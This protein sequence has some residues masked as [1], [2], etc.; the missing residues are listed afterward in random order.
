[1]DNERTTLTI[2][3]RFSSPRRTLT[4]ATA[5][6]LLGATLLACGGGE[7]EDTR[8]GGQADKTA[9]I[10]SAG[11]GGDIRVLWVGD[12]IAGAQAPAL[13]A[14][15]EAAGVKFRN[16]ASDGGGTIVAGGDEITK[17][18]SGDTWKT[19]G[20]QIGSFKPTV[21]AYQI[22]TYDWGT[23]EQ[24][25]DAYG[26]LV[27]TAEEIGAKA[28]FISAPPIEIDDFYRPHAKQMKTAPESAAETA[29]AHADKAL[30]VDS[31]RLWG[32]DAS[33]P[34]AGRAADGIHNCRQG[35]AAFANWFVKVLGDEEGFTPA[36]PGAWA[37]GEWTDDKRF[38]ALGCES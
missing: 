20:K 33:A 2:H 6:V 5:A 18:L 28:V 35:A 38:S 30:F 10:E 34:K 9:A 13:G 31:G 36:K 25:R 29:E 22:T 19:L 24:Q 23:A 12:S 17:K 27:S 15:L 8:S 16:A 3:R 11:S 37:T 21:I 1:M 7:G 4:A 26:K 14:A 32:E